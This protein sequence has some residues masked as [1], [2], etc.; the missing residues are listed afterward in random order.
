MKL[1]IAENTVDICGANSLRQDVGAVAMR[2][3]QVKVEFREHALHAVEDGAA[4]ARAFAKVKQRDVAGANAVKPLG[5]SSSLRALAGFVAGL[6]PKL[7]HRAFD[8]GDGLFRAARTV[9]DDAP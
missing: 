2:E 7:P 6:V 5:A 9:V 3:D 1:A 8:R 4:D